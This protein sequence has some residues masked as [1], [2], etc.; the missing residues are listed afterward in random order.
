MGLHFELTAAT[1]QLSGRPFRSVEY[2]H[3]TPA[4]TTTVFSN[5]VT[6]VCITALR[7]KPLQ[8]TRVASSHFRALQVHAC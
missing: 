2:C 6:H 4:Y 7:V 5:L 3:L 8:T 1:P